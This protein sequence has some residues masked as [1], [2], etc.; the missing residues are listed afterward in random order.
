MR[1]FGSFVIAE[2][3]GVGR[4]CTDQDC[5]SPSPSAMPNRAGMA[6]RSA[7][8]QRAKRTGLGMLS[9]GSGL[10]ALRSILDGSVACPLNTYAL[11]AVV[12]VA[13][14]ILL[15]AARGSIPD[16]FAEMVDAAME[17]QMLPTVRLLP[18]RSHSPVPPVTTP[19]TPSTSLTTRVDESA[20][21]GLVLDTIQG[22][23]GADVNDTQPLMEAGLDSLGE[24]ST[25][26]LAC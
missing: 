26:L 21:L 23:L 4:H 20:V 24:S 14:Q 9:P 19:F 22:I 1:H 25:V 7:V 10:D 18:A 8:E 11:T 17:R 5:I 3:L 12:P 15:R 6:A 2:Q 16:F 13:W